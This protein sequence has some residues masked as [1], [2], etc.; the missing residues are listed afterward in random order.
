MGIHH[1]GILSKC[2][3]GEKNGANFSSESKLILQPEAREKWPAH[4]YQLKITAAAQ[5][6][7]MDKNK[8]TNIIL[9]NTTG[10]GWTGWGKVSSQWKKDLRN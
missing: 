10:G 4:S 3:A 2:A 5:N 1:E 8:I 9:K 7:C 6:C